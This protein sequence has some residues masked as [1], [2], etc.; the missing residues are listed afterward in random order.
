MNTSFNNHVLNSIL[1]E[2][3]SNSVPGK[4]I[5]IGAVSFM[6]GFKLDAQ[7]FN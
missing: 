1:T 6:N 5:Q 7:A 3:S 2:L 4:R